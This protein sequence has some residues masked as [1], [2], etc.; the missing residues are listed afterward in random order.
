MNIKPLTFS[1]FSGNFWRN[2]KNKIPPIFN[3]RLAL[4]NGFAAVNKPMGF[5]S[6]DVI[7]KVKWSIV[8]EIEPDKEKRRLIFSTLKVGHGGTLDPNATGVLVLGFGDAC[9]RFEEYL[10]G[11]KEYISVGR[12]GVNHDTDD[13][14]GKIIEEKPT[15]HVSIKKLEQI[16][17]HYRGPIMQVPP[18]YSAISID[19]VRMYKLAIKGK[20]Q[21]E[22]PAR[23]ITIYELELRSANLPEFEI[24]ALCSGGTYVRSLIRDIGKDLGTCASMVSLVRTRQGDFGLNDCLSLDEALS[25]DLVVKKLRK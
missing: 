22:I 2:K 13:V 7:Q 20:P 11:T 5:T 16:L 4:L 15:D 9:K 3:A 8:H 1:K 24:R 14:W 17:T 23:P 19:G 18:R 21:P 25:F 6:N 12:L 10:K